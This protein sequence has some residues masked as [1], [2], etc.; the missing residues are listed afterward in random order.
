MKDIQDNFN[1]RFEGDPSAGA[2]WIPF[3]RKKATFLL[4]HWKGN[5]GIGYKIYD[6]PDGSRITISTNDFVGS[7]RTITIRTGGYYEGIHFGLVPTNISNTIDRGGAVSFFPFYKT[8][9]KYK[10]LPSIS[11]GTV[12]QHVFDW[13]DPT[14]GYIADSDPSL[15]LERGGIHKGTNLDIT[16]YANPM[17]ATGILRKLLLLKSGE[18]RKW[19]GK[20]YDTNTSNSTPDW[21]PVLGSD[22][23]ILSGITVGHNQSNFDYGVI[24]NSNGDDFY[25]AVGRTFSWGL[26]FLP[27]R[28]KGGKAYTSG[29]KTYKMISDAELPPIIAKGDGGEWD[30]AP[31]PGTGEFSYTGMHPYYATQ[32]PSAT[33]S[34]DTKFS[35]YKAPFL[36]ADPSVL[37]QS[38]SNIPSNSACWR[39]SDSGRKLS[40]CNFIEISDPAMK[41]I[42]SYEV[43]IYGQGTSSSPFSCAVT[44]KLGSYR[45]GFFSNLTSTIFGEKPFD[46]DAGDYRRYGWY[47]G[48]T[49]IKEP[50]VDVY[51]N[52]G[53][54]GN[55]YAGFKTLGTLLSEAPFPQLIAQNPSLSSKFNSI[56]AS[57][58]SE[59]LS[60]YDLNDLV[61]FSNN[62]TLFN[63]GLFSNA[64]LSFVARDSFCS[65][66]SKIDCVL[67]YSRA[68]GSSIQD[69]I[70][71]YNYNPRV[72]VYNVEFTITIFGDDV[73]YHI[74]RVLTGAFLYAG[75]ATNPDAYSWEPVVKYYDG[76]SKRFSQNSSI[77][78]YMNNPV[79]SINSNIHKCTFGAAESFS[80]K[81]KV[82]SKSVYADYNENLKEFTFHSDDS[83]RSVFVNV[84]LTNVVSYV[85]SIK[86]IDDNFITNT[87]GESLVNEVIRYPLIISGNI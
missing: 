76:K 20:V 29:G 32:T 84:P 10:I 6:M 51:N 8:S 80:G 78:Y 82:V 1:I 4:E 47:V 85:D 66:H 77:S 72:P 14:S 30:F 9:Q 83:F 39:F 46:V 74:K 3:A 64:L 11:S 7:P 34:M 61:Y 21:A 71:G 52:F 44:T 40:A 79:Y 50:Y 26:F 56:K 48:E 28:Y 87:T 13:N 62:G 18:S 31:Y 53:S 65:N 81:L 41:F 35:A 55:G 58:E 75:G 15:Q 68:G 54:Y 27:V 63:N 43:T 70:D 17:C 42:E 16:R 5:G 37:M 45:S 12:Q 23:K 49:F 38:S 24:R 25:V 69:E 33:S 2:M 19:N 57:I 59:L 22:G 86:L 67:L 36:K 60:T 73:S